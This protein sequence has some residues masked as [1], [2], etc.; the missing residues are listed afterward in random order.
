MSEKK[1]HVEDLGH[2]TTYDTDVNKKNNRSCMTSSDGQMRLQH[3]A[4]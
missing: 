1:K 4:Q 2:G 3:V